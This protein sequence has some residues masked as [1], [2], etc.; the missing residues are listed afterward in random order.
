MGTWKD[1][2]LKRKPTD[3]E[4][5]QTGRL[6]DAAEQW[7]KQNDPEYAEQKAGWIVSE[8]DA[9]ARSDEIHPT[10]LGLQAVGAVGDGNYRR[11]PTT[12]GDESEADDA[13]GMSDDLDTGE[14]GDTPFDLGSSTPALADDPTACKISARNRCHWRTCVRRLRAAGWS[15]RRVADHL[16]VHHRSV[17]RVRKSM[18]CK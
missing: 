2:G 6:D 17:Q 8:T 1:L 4:D 5:F 7:L 3:I 18:I 13:W 11:G 16:G 10:L 15:D 12:T 14:Y 9:L